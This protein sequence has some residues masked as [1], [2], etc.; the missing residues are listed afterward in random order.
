M[1][2]LSHYGK[3]L[4]IQSRCYIFCGIIAM[5][6]LGCSSSP[7]SPSV[8][9]DLEMLQRNEKLVIGWISTNRI[10]FIDFADGRREKE[11]SITPAQR[12]QL[13]QKFEAVV[14]GSSNA[15]DSPD[16]AWRVKRVES[17]KFTLVYIKTGQASDLNFGRRILTFPDWSS[18]SQYLMWAQS[19]GTWSRKALSCGVGAFQVVVLRVR[20]REKG[21]V[22]EFCTGYPYGGFHWMR[23]P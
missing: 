8:V 1:C 11:I 9:R 23:V 4:V 20:D 10:S 3:T 12:E 5:V 15:F 7:P 18:D 17:E 16:G 2:R 21:V 14:P 6:F 19:A 22:A 13:I